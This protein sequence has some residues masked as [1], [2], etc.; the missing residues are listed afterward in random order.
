MII[1]DCPECACWMPA[2][3]EDSDTRCYD[4]AT[5]K[6]NR[7]DDDPVIGAIPFDDVHDM[8]V[9]CVTPWKCNGPHLSGGEAA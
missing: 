8:C 4:C 6:H 1:C 9:N 3:V 5:G 2:W 7:L